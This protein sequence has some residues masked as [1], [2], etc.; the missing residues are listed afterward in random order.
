MGKEIGR[1]KKAEGSRNRANTQ[2]DRDNKPAR[3]G[4]KWGKSG[5][6]TEDQIGGLA[7]VS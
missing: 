5:G 7:V 6:V 3:M 4:L 1:G 2:Q